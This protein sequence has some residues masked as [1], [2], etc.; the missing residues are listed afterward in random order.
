M[1]KEKKE[2]WFWFT[3]YM[4]ILFSGM[5]LG[6]LLQQAIIKR[7]II[8]IGYSF[9]GMIEEVNFNIN[10]TRMVE[11]LKELIPPVK[12]NVNIGGYNTTITDCTRDSMPINCSEIEEALNKILEEDEI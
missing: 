1:K 9:A 3:I 5:F 6:M 12:T 7:G 10:E 4:F 8:S 11:G 2:K